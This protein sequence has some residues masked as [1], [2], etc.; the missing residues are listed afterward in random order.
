[1]AT[2][3]PRVRRTRRITPEEKSLVGSLAQGT[4]RLAKLV[5]QQ[6]FFLLSCLREDKTSL[7]FIPKTSSHQY[8]FLAGKTD[9]NHLVKTGFASTPKGSRIGFIADGA[10]ITLP[11]IRN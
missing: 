5:G 9:S 6:F 1:M 7:Y 3:S 8:S 11:P 10:L 4:T 2:K